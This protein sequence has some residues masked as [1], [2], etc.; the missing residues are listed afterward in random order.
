MILAFFY[1]MFAFGTCI[2]M[3]T[4]EFEFDFVHML[5]NTLFWPMFWSSM[6]CCNLMDK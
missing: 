1:T 2:A 3:W 6:I 5:M 4:S